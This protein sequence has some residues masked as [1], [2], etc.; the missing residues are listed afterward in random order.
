MDEF[1]RWRMK[2]MTVQD[3]IIVM[4]DVFFTDRPPNTLQ[5]DHRCP[6]KPEGSPEPYNRSPKLL[7]QYKI[8]KE[9]LKTTMRNPRTPQGSCT[10][11]SRTSMISL[12]LVQLKLKSKTNPSVKLQTAQRGKSFIDH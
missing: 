7:Y 8:L 11:I 10:K 1:I 4:A 6:T 12:F 2:M 9:F 5:L 3:V